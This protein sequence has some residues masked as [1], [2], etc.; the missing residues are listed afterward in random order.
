MVEFFRVPV[1]D[2]HLASFDKDSSS[3]IKLNN[4]TI[5]YLRE[6]SK[7]LALVCILREDNFI[8]PGT[9]PMVVLRRESNGPLFQD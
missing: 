5:L 6:V 1:E 7:Y 4:N 9:K 3:I 8:K 2:E